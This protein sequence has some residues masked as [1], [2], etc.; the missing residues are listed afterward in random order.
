[1]I[2]DKRVVNMDIAGFTFPLCMTVQA[3][4]EFTNQFGSYDGWR[5]A[6]TA[7]GSEMAA[8]NATVDL[9]YIMMQGGRS[10]V[11]LL[12]RMAGE[13]ANLPAD[14]SKED[15][16]SLIALP[17]LNDI[18]MLLL[19]A[20]TAGTETTVEVAPDSSKNAEATQL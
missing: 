20:F 18:Q 7:D 4:E 10:R 5:E 12:A 15:L 11:S 19:K 14:L 13:E 1:M 17:E 3:Q 16:R 9:M 8:V 6:L 2:S